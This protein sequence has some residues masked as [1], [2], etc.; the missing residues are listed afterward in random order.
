MTR[1][2]KVLII[3]DDELDRMIVKRAINSSG[4]LVEMTFAEDMDSGRDATK[5]QYYDCI[6]LDYNLPGGTGLQLLKDIRNSGNDSPIIIVTSHGDE[7]IA[8][9]AMKSGASD[10]IPKNL[11]TPDGLAQSLRYVVRMRQNEERRLLVERE[12]K[13]TQKRLQTVVANSPIVLF[14]IDAAGIFTL[15]EGK[16]V[17]NFGI[18]T[19]ELAGKNINDVTEN[20]PITKQDYTDAMEGKE[21][22]RIFEIGEKFFE[23]S[24]AQLRDDHDAINGV[25][26]VASDITTFKQAEQQL[27]QAKKMAEEASQMKE[28]FLAN[29][30]HEIRTPMNGIVGLTR[31]LLNT[32]GLDEEQMKY[33]QSIKISSDNLMIIINDILDVSKIEAGKMTFEEIPFSVQDIV[34]HAKE[35]FMSKVDEKGLD[36]ICE[37]DSE[38]PKQLLGDPTRLSQILNN[39]V[40]NAIKF[41]S[42]GYVLMRVKVRNTTNNKVMLDFEVKDTG[43][44]IPQESISSIFESFTQAS[45]ETSRKFGG[46]GLGLTI[47]KKLIELQHGSIGIK[48]KVNEGTTFT[49]N[50]TYSVADPSMIVTKSDSFAKYRNED[51]SHLHVLCAEDNLINQM[52][53]K[54][55]LSEWNVKAVFADNGRIAIDKLRESQGNGQK[56]F[57]IILMDVQMPE[58]DGFTATKYI[59]TELPSPLSGTPILAV[60][61]SATSMGMQRCYDC[62]MNDFISKPYDHDELRK[63]IIELTREKAGA[64]MSMATETIKTPAKD[65]TVTATDKPETLK[66]LQQTIDELQLQKES[67]AKS[68]VAAGQRVTDLNHLRKLAD[69]NIGFVIEMVEMFLAKTP[70]EIKLVEDYFK[71]K[72]WDE[73]RQIAHKIKPTFGYVGLK[74]IQ[75]TLATVESYCFNKHNLDKLKPL[76]EKV[77]AVSQKAFKELEAE[78]TAM[79]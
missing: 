43:I 68:T 26:G 79:K 60:T 49:F 45:S 2:I 31:I 23:V 39:L 61:G 32:K 16:G 58:M 53:L 4:M 22:K 75:D 77:S 20:L 13:A 14:S 7:K 30:S 29:M 41:T 35:L 36:L 72:E 73:L 46:T 66:T 27:I 33:L 44:G 78:L 71:N 57:D 9:E 64:E 24:Y 40:S 37:L 59:R 3:E 51:M 47:V 62:G 12:L 21:V 54:K 10:Y 28:Q 8:V 69:G 11:L 17:S 38:V 67:A 74:D 6:F 25:I 70:A 48:S 42:K 15:F 1:P 34:N 52:V 56:P 19:K 55:I 18:D 65:R 50:I 5:D 63:K 76:I